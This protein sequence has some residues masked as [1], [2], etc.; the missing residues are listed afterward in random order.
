[1]TA[2]SNRMRDV[3]EEELVRIESDK[4]KIDNLLQFSETM[5]LASFSL[6]SITCARLPFNPK[7]SIAMISTN[8]LSIVSVSVC[9]LMPLNGASRG[10]G[11]T[12]V[13]YGIL[14]AIVPKHNKKE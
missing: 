7:F 9:T 6:V 2:H 3:A 10:C 4:D 1:M 11:P 13:I 12:C 14:M 8:Q 5:K